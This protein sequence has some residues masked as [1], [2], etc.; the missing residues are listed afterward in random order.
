MIYEK[1]KYKRKGQALIAKGSD[2][3]GNIGEK[4]Y[5]EL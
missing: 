1:P 3:Y 5:E 2:P 4:R